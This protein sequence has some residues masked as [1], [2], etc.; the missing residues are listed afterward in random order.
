MSEGNTEGTPEPGDSVE[1]KRGASTQFDDLVA[2]CRT[3]HHERDLA[4]HYGVT[5]P[6]MTAELKRQGIIQ[7]TRRDQVDWSNLEQLYADLLSVPAVARHL[8]TTMKITYNELKRQGIELRPPGHLKGQKK[9][10]AWREASARHWDDPAWRDEQRRKWLERLPTVR[11]TGRSSRP[12]M[13]LRKALRTARISYTANAL[14][15]DGTYVVDI[16]IT[17]KLVIVEADGAS[18][19]LRSAREKDARRDDD[20]RSQGF[21]VSRF[22]YRDIEDDPD[23]CIRR[24]VIDYGLTAEADPTFIDRSDKEAFGERINELRK[25]PEWRAQWI[26]RLTEGQRRRRERESGR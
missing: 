21:S 17:Q 9:S 5:V 23:A 18:H 12:E 11:G 19:F 10:Q 6:E 20:L 3:V 2:V 8:R 13:L 26:E 25:D 14:L 1:T 16:L 24:L 4:K 15:S 22:D 7:F